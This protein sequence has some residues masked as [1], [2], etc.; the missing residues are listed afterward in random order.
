MNDKNSLEI[1]IQHNFAHF[2]CYKFPVF[3]S[4]NIQSNVYSCLLYTCLLTTI[5]LIFKTGTSVTMS[6]TLQKLKNIVYKVV[7]IQGSSLRPVRSQKLITGRDIERVTVDSTRVSSPRWSSH[8]AKTRTP[9]R[10]PSTCFAV[11]SVVDVVVPSSFIPL[12]RHRIR[13]RQYGARLFLANRYQTTFSF[14][15]TPLGFNILFVLVPRTHLLFIFELR[16]SIRTVVTG[17]ICF[18]FFFQ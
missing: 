10:V 13:L 11:F 8:S 18:L 14:R 5:F 2:P 9:T 3:F 4:L 7:A 15:R 1:A 12:L 17:W 16:F 6:E